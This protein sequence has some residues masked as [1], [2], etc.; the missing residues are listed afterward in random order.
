MRVSRW[1]IFLARLLLLA[2]VLFTG[3]YCLLAY[4]PF[5]YQQIHVGQLLP[6]LTRLVGM[7]PWLYWPA[8]AAAIL[9]I[10]P[11]LKAGPARHLAR[12]F[13]V[14]GVLTGIV[15][16][17][18]PLLLNLGNDTRSLMWCLLSLL[19][20]F[21]MAA[22]D[23]LQSGKAVVWTHGE[24]ESAAKTFFAAWQAALYLAMLEFAIAY[25]RA[26]S[27]RGLRWSLSQWGWALLWTILSHLLIFLIL[28]VMVDLVIALAGLLPTQRKSQ[29]TFLGTA[30]VVVAAIALTV[31]YIFF[32]PLSFGG[33]AA[34]LVAAALAAGLVAF[35]SGIGVR[36]LNAE[37]NLNPDIFD[38][39]LLPFR[40][41][42]KTN[43][44]GQVLTLTALGAAA[45]ILAAGLGRLDW[46]FL[47]QK[48]AALV[49]W[50][51]AFA[52]FYSVAPKAWFSR[53]RAYAVAAAVLLCYLGL[54]LMQSYAAS[55]S[56]TTNSNDKLFNQYADYDVS[57]RLADD[58]LRLEE[59]LS[60]GPGSS[61]FT[62][63]A[64]NTNIP[65]STHL[66]PVNIT[67]ANQQDSTPARKPHI[68]LIVI[69]S[70]RRDYL[71]PYNPSIKFT[72]VIE[73]LA[74]DSVVFQNAFT[75]YGGTGLSEPSIW[76]GGLMVHQQY[77]TPFAP[78]NSLQKLVESEGYR[79]WIS[80]DTILEQTVPRSPRSQDLDEHVGTM[81]Y[82]LCRTL[83]EVTSRLPVNDSDPVFVYT[84]AQNIHVSVIDREGR[85]VLPGK[86]IPSEFNAAYASRI[87]RMDTCLGKLID[88]LKT[89]GMY[90]N[91]ILI[92]T[93]D[94]G[95]SLG[96]R[97]RWGHA[98]T[99]FPEIV[100]IPL[101]VHLPG[102]MRT[103]AQY[104]RQAAA[105]LTDLTPTLYYLLGLK[106]IVNHP[107]FGRP[108]F[109]ASLEEQAP[110]RRDAYLV[111]SSYAPV[112]GLLTRNGGSL[113]IADGV[114]YRDY[115]YQL[116]PDGTTRDLNLSEEQRS[117]MQEE[118]RNQ[119]SAI[120]QFYGLR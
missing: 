30:L 63:L 10:L 5:T 74:A 52:V 94:H 32:P 103:G 114:S 24:E 34:S 49:L 45:W 64:E 104:D 72:P 120:A 98:Y 9:T 7:H 11:D 91:S 16:A 26:W 47:L 70:L 85:S 115:A 78:M 36:F 28:F 87:Q 86:S 62:F 112:Y 89:T 109:T 1:Q 68:F 95:D 2:Y 79:Q 111:A 83:D 73:S 33:P 23:W 102:W 4:I 41:L 76:V 22:I 117:Q 46:E 96:E 3:S 43:W 88:A 42:A 18:H 93:S 61:F 58:L 8:F 97:G 31:R 106:P 99:I 39:L 21:W 84:Q 40:F 118:I 51:L 57:F 80:R 59:G 100:R 105:F 65:R 27:S 66:S 53:T 90:D 15:L 37:E 44:S 50:T 55:E 75:R 82:D 12:G 60:S 20:L 14:V 67:L 69:D 19:P 17:V 116:L 101:I 81:Y 113:Y 56:G 54:M 77:V 25:F 6:W 107:V 29:G 119:V 110:Y 48:M 71:S 35:A 92:L 108:L 13:A 38:L